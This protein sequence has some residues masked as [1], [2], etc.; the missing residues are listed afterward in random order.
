MAPV[1]ERSALI[2]KHTS[3]SL[4]RETG[5]STLLPLTVTFAISVITAP[6]RW[7]FG[8]S[9][10]ALANPVGG[11]PRCPRPIRPPPLRPQCLATLQWNAE[12]QCCR[13]LQTST[14]LEI[15]C[16]VLSR[17]PPACGKRASRLQECT[18][19]STHGLYHAFPKTGSPAH[20]RNVGNCSEVLNALRP[21]RSRPDRASHNGRMWRDR[22][23]VCRLAGTADK[24]ST[25]LPRAVG[26][27]RLPAPAHSRRH[28]KIVREG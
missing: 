17:Y 19:L 9:H 23:Y 10:R 28:S 16:K 1:F 22:W 13:Q 7:R 2:S 4:P 5:R 27:L 24:H 11:R 3:P 12:V 21:A 8:R 6:H 26:R 18:T 25:T 15:P 14:L 20:H